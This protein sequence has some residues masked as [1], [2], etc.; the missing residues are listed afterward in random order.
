M[1]GSCLSS[2]R[3]G[4]PS[5]ERFGST[6]RKLARSHPCVMRRAL[7]SGATSTSLPT[8]PMSLASVIAQNRSSAGPARCS[9]PASGSVV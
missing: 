1:T 4:A 3:Y 7:P 5:R 9:G 2:G 6:A 8:Q